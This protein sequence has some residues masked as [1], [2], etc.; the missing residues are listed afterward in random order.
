MLLDGYVVGV[1]G[2]FFESVEVLSEYFCSV[3]G[4]FLIPLKYFPGL[5][6]SMGVLLEYFVDSLG[7]VFEYLLYA[8][9][10]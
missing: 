5:S 4:Y 3:A 6:C 1:W 8:T 10:Y 7:H 2:Y 9:G